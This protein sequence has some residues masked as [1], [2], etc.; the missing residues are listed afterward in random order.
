[1]KKDTNE[2][3]LLKKYAE[4]TANLFNLLDDMRNIILKQ[5]AIIKQLYREKYNENFINC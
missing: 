1:M 5:D 3:E 4:E 2:K